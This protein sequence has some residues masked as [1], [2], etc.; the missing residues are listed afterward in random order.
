MTVVYDAAV[1]M[2]VI[3]III[4]MTVKI[5][6]MLEIQEYDGAMSLSSKY[7][8]NDAASLRQGRGGAARGGI[9]DDNGEACGAAAN[10]EAEYG[11]NVGVNRRWW[12][13]KLKE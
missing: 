7:D 10:G 2:V 1:L 8:G 13:C 5:G 4:V 6:D 12:Q 9:D 11:W 3:I